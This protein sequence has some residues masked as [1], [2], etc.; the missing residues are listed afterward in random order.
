MLQSCLGGIAED[1]NVVFLRDR[2][3]RFSVHSQQV[4]FYVHNLRHFKSSEFV[5]FFFLWGNG[6]PNFIHE[7]RQWETEEQRSWSV[8]KPKASAH[9][10]EPLLSGANAVPLGSANRT[11][12][13]PPQH[14]SLP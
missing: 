7:F 2:T 11:V 1:F 14:R 5:V 3:Y 12:S 6:G 13:Q 10:N 9:T 8:V 4:G